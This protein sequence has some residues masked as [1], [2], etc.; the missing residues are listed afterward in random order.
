[1]QI[2]WILILSSFAHEIIREINFFHRRQEANWFPWRSSLLIW[3][4]PSKWKSFKSS[5]RLDNPSLERSNRSSINFVLENTSNFWWAVCFPS[6]SAAHRMESIHKH[7]KGVLYNHRVNRKVNKSDCF[8]ISSNLPDFVTSLT[9]TAARVP[10]ASSSC[11]RAWKSTRR[12][13]K[14]WKNY[15]IC[16]DGRSN[17]IN[18][19]R[20]EN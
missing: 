18:M 2:P 7:T 5:Q 4:A 17:P 16:H 15:E 13:G 6:V 20:E 3:I 12:R 10:N 14:L 19:Q 9:N 8:V 11:S 1:M